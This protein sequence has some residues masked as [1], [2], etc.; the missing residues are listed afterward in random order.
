[1]QA[2]STDSFASKALASF[3]WHPRAYG[4]E[5]ATGVVP[6]G[7]VRKSVHFAPRSRIVKAFQACLG[8]PVVFWLCCVFIAVVSVH[9]AA[10]I[11]VNH[12]VIAEFEQN[13]I[14]RWFLEMQGGDV[15]LFVFVKLA[16]TSLVCALLVTMFHTYQRLGLLT[17]SAVAS[18]QMA[19]LCYLSLA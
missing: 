11:V 5:G 14:G 16:T 9:D 3:K 6:L 19:L 8:A 13:P 12:S 4:S 18:F 7:V 2:S 10:L 15:W 1:M 17:V